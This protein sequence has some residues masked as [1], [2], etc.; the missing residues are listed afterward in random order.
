MR[1]SYLKCLNKNMC[2][3]GLEQFDCFQCRWKANL[4]GHYNQDQRK[5]DCICI[6][7]DLSHNN[8]F[9]YSLL[10]RDNLLLKKRNKF[11]SI[12]LDLLENLALTVYC[13]ETSK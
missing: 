2:M 13:T 1:K 12:N 7:S 6:D 9:H 5:E 8:H 11:E 10:D 3:L 4:H